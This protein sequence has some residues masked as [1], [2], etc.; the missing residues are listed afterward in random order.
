MLQVSLDA[1]HLDDGWLS[2]SKERV[3]QT[4]V[5]KAPEP[6]VLKVYHRVRVAFDNE[7]VGGQVWQ[8]GVVRYVHARQVRRP[9]LERGPSERAHASDACRAARGASDACRAAGARERRM[10][11]GAHE[12]RMSGGA[13][14]ERRTSG[15]ARE[16]LGAVCSDARGSTRLAVARH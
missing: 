5:L 6:T 16:P 4:D 15:G 13:R 3:T 11:G 1:L 10:S 2:E 9:T 8:Y 14:R 7:Y 12:R